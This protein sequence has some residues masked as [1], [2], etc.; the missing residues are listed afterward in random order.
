MILRESSIRGTHPWDRRRIPDMLAAS[1]R[2]WPDNVAVVEECH[3]TTFGELHE[4]VQR[5]AANLQHLGV[6]EGDRV[7]LI[8]P[9]GLLAIVLHYAVAELGAVV[10]PLNIWW[11]ADEAFDA[12]AQCA[13]Q[14]V[15][16]G[17]EVRG[18]R[19]ASRLATVIDR[20]R[21]L[22]DLR[23]VVSDDEGRGI[24]LALLDLLAPRDAEISRSDNEAAYIIFTSGSTA[25]PKPAV[26]AHAA[27]LGTSYYVAER[28]GMHPGDR[29]VNVL[30]FFHSGALVVCLY[31]AH[32]S[33]TAIY[34]F[35]SVDP[36]RMIEPMA[37]GLPVVTGGFDVVTMRL[38][39]EASR[40]L[41][42]VPIRSMISA[43]GMATFDTITALGID[44]ANIYALTEGTCVV[45]ITAPDDSVDGRRNSN[46]FPLPG[47]EVAVRNPSTGERVDADEWGE[48]GFRGWNLMFG[49]M[50]QNG[51][52]LLPIDDDGF[53]WTGD[54]GSLDQAGRLY[55][56]GRY[57]AMIKTGGE[58]VSEAEVEM[59][60][61]SQVDGVTQAAVVGV[62]D[63]KW[64]EM[65]VAFV[66]SERNLGTEDVRG[67]CRGR[68]ASYKMP[69][70][71]VQIDESDWP[72]TGSGKI[73]KTALKA[74]ATTHHQAEAVRDRS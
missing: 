55:Y 6:V 41:G 25:R 27:L 4:L 38:V 24:D 42:R 23:S 14:H 50:Q 61:T 37:D 67:E 52:L 36:A 46:G 26:L 53:Y 44:H 34:M 5:A 30:P 13:A 59:F 7:V 43:P 62:P 19:L 22:P 73:D 48:I 39:E 49:Y 72:T 71:V 69:Q 40:T 9:E 20:R 65:V 58:N 10:V 57:S 54:Y 18:T 47:V 1:A 31:A 2:Q 12:V 74:L 64:G 15:I 29:Y 16:A 66:Q 17:G 28:L 63:P 45:S 68:L 21:E 33:G 60:L 70:L 8:L 32:Q 51:D 3:D 35:K 56:R 11:E